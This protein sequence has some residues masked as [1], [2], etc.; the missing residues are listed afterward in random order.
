MREGFT[1]GYVCVSLAVLLLHE[2][3]SLLFRKKRSGENSGM[4][5][6]QAS[7]N[8]RPTDDQLENAKKG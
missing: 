3:S 6:Q 7:K 2:L 5:E 4:T 1:G 8:I